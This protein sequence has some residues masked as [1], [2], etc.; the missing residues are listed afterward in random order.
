MGIKRRE[1]R[2]NSGLGG[3]KGNWAG[4]GCGLELVGCSLFQKQKR[5]N[6]RKEKERKQDV[7]EA[8]WERS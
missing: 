1:A 8:I 2:V 6:R 3:L 5:N 4:L 7:R